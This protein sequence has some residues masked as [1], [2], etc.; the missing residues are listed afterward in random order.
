M[1]LHLP[2]TRATDTLTR[3]VQHRVIPTG[4]L[5]VRAGGSGPGTFEGWA[6]LWD[7]VDSY[8]TRWLRGSWLAGGLDS[9]PYALLWM[10]DAR[11]VLGSFVAEE[12]DKGLWIAGSFDPTPEGQAAR[13]RAVSGSAPAL[14]VGFG[15]AITSPDDS[16]AFIASELLEVSQITARMQSTPGAG[17]TKARAADLERARTEAQDRARRIARARLL[18]A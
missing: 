3:E 12:R 5:E 15:A 8:G 14:S 2:R 16:T 6:N 18:L 17:L 10:H 9:E 1:T 7:V 13:Q 11:V 4:Q